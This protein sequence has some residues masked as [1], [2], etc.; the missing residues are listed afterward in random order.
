MERAAVAIGQHEAVAVGEV[1]VGRVEDHL[2]GPQ[3][4]RD[5]CATQR[6]ARV[7][8]VCALDSVR[9]ECADRVDALLHRSSRFGA[10]GCR[11]LHSFGFCFFLVRL[12]FERL[13][14]EFCMYVQKSKVTKFATPRKS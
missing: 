6:G 1:G 12:N 10:L 3:H 14:G 5:G 2:I 11:L 9:R 13:S 8:G 4:V 7:T